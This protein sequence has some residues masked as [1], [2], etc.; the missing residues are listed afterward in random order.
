MPTMKH[1]IFL[2]LTDPACVL[3]L[4][5]SAA[6]FYQYIQCNDYIMYSSLHVV[7][8]QRLSIAV[9]GNIHIAK[10]AGYSI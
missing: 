5:V 6:L 7:S 8:F 4:L 10:H 2:P 1:A 9:T 3:V